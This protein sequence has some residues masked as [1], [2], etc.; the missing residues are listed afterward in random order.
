VRSEKQAGLR[1]VVCETP[2]SGGDQAA[3]LRWH[4]VVPDGEVKSSSGD[5]VLNAEG[6]AA[7]IAEFR[8]RGVDLPVDYEHQTLG[9]EFSSPTG[10]APAAGWIK[11]LRYTPGAGLY[12]GVL[13]NQRGL[14][15]ISSRE[16]G[17]FSPVTLVRKKDQVMTG[18][19]SV[20]LTNVPAIEQMERIAASATLRKWIDA[21]ENTEVQAMGTEQ[22]DV[23]ANVGGLTGGVTPTASPVPPPAP[24]PG[25]PAPGPPAPGAEGTGVGASP[26]LWAM[27]A[28]AFGLPPG[29]DFATIWAKV[30]EFVE[31]NRAAAGGPAAGGPAAG[32]GEGGEAAM[33]ASLR[34]VFGLAV[35][36]DLETIVNAAKTTAKH[37]GMVPLD[38]HNTLVTRVN[39]MEADDKKRRAEGVLAGAI[40]A[41]KIPNDPESAGYKFWKE[42]AEADPEG[43]ATALAHV[44]GIETGRITSV[45]SGGGRDDRSTVIA[46]ATAE[47]EDCDMKVGSLRTNVDQALKDK[48]LKKLTKD[49]A[50]KLEE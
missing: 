36:A 38:Q 29:A 46:K 32:E 8:K 18:L 9:G 33:A 42:R 25:P 15:Q 30:A 49:E 11:E 34:T 19:H 10:E 39:A 40:Q 4:L 50:E 48:G 2:T 31:A 27:L 7:T 45:D 35:D 5:F 6:A 43:T 14:G 3:G 16:Y 41:N 23:V 12:A 26:G 17:Y 47:F 24:P 1:L 20:A 13:W 22:K 21:F 37:E 28:K 44:A